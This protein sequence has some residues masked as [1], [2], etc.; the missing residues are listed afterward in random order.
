MLSLF[1]VLTP[2]GQVANVVDRCI[3]L[4]TNRFGESCELVSLLRLFIT[5]YGVFFVGS[6]YEKWM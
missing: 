1:V 5:L 2:S 6:A 3:V 4:F